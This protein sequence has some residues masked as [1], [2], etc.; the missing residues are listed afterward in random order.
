M[1]QQLEFRFVID[2]GTYRV[3]SSGALFAFQVIHPRCVQYKLKYNIKYSIINILCYILTLFDFLHDLS[4]C[5]AG[6]RMFRGGILSV[7]Y[8]S[9]ATTV[10][11]LKMCDFSGQTSKGFEV[12]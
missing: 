3:L 10:S 7:T 9:F 12:L 1:T 6:K 8:R 2:V 5:S 11:R 4:N